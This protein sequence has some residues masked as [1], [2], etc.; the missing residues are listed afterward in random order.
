MPGLIQDQQT[1][2]PLNLKP[3]HPTFGAEITDVDL[4]NVAE[5][6]FQ[7]VLAAMAKV[8]SSKIISILHLA[9]NCN[10]T[11]SSSSATQA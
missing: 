1:T 6:T 7:Q 10:S 11:A 4:T 8:V 2:Q 9:D 5:E 3:L